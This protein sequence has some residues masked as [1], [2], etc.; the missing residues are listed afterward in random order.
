MFTLYD[1]LEVIKAYTKK[2][3]ERKIIDKRT[4]RILQSIV[5]DYEMT[6][7]NIEIT[8]AKLYGKKR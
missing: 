2:Y 4:L 7:L 3:A 5:M 1:K 8:E 6:I